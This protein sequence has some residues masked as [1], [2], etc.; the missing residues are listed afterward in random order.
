MSTHSPT[1]NSGSV[2]RAA[3]VPRSRSVSTDDSQC[4]ASALVVKV[5]GAVSPS[6]RRAWYRPDGKRRML[7]KARRPTGAPT[8]QT[9]VDA[10]MDRKARPERAGDAG[11]IVPVGCDGGREAPAR[12]LRAN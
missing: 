3:Y 7:P 8:N 11:S 4:A 10:A 12:S 5:T 2:G 9:A 1:V 6:G